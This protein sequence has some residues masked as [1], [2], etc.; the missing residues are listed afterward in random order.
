MVK[1]HGPDHLVLVCLV[2]I[3]LTITGCLKE[4][5]LPTVTTAEVSE[6]KTR[7]AVSGGIINDDGGAEINVSGIC[8]GTTANPT[9]DNSLSVSR[10][11][12]TSTFECLLFNL[13]PDTYYH[14]RAFARN[15]AGT[16]YGN[17][18]TFK[19][20]PIAAKVTTVSVDKI[21]FTCARVQGKIECDD[22][23]VLL[24]KGFC[25]DTIYNPTVKNEIIPS[26]SVA[27]NYV[28][29]HCGLKPGTLYHV[30]AFAAT[31]LGITYGEDICFTTYKVPVVETKV[32][33]ITR[34]SVLIEAKLIFD[35]LSKIYTDAMGVYIRDTANPEKITY[36]DPWN[37]LDDFIPTDK[38]FTYRPKDLASG[39]LYYIRAYFY[40]YYFFI[41]GSYEEFELKG[42][43]VSFTT[44]R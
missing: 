39:T 13:T 44:D 31:L 40:V 16:A 6:I 18:V 20:L 15:R 41:A 12:G 25:F 24:G 1:S 9:T 3:G 17:E 10:T 35:D 19:S 37:P 30:R 14:V 8:W 4:A 32:S 7:S 22:E 11:E 34:N 38:G 23:S 27:G 36:W 33:E 21:G 42:A 2:S 28:G 29:S 26:L 5:G 43:E